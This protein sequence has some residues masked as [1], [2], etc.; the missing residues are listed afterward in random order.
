MT[1][2]AAVTARPV[3][4][5]ANRVAHAIPLILLP[6]CLWRLP[7]AWG[8]EMGMIGDEQAMPWW[9]PV[10]VVALSVVSEALALLSFGLVRVWGEVVPG[11][12]PLLGG[13]RI[14][15]YVA[16]VP[17]VLGSLAAIALWGQEVLAWFGFAEGLAGFENI[18]WQVLAQVC[19]TPG[20][21]WGPLVLA[22]T[23]AYVIR[24][25]RQG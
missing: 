17:A 20:I 22:L 6:H 9:A 13:R 24:R 5:W 12:V 18:W 3:P 1:T 23:V 8:F 11:W 16:V 25:R 21:L 2:Y 15:P 7:F 19:I 10:Y 14:P 4:V